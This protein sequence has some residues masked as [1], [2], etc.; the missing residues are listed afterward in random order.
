[1]TAAT[2]HARRW[3][4]VAA[5]AAGATP[6]RW[7][8]LALLLGGVLAALVF[9]PAAW[10]AQLVASATSQRVLLA[11]AQGTVWQGDAVLVLG[12]GD[13]SRAAVA[14]PGRLTWQLSWVGTGF[15][16][17]ARQDCCLNDNFRLLVEPGFGRMRL[18]LQPT[19]PSTPTTPTTP[20]TA[21]TALPSALGQW[22]TAWLAGL[23]A[24]WNTLQLGGV[25]RLHSTGWVLDSAQGRH[26]FTGHAELAVEGLSSRLSTLPLLGNYKLTVDGQ[27]QAGNSAALALSTQQGPLL[28]N[29]TGQFGGAMGSSANTL[30]FRGEARA[31]PEA[32][33]ALNNLLNVI[34][35]RQGAVSVLSIG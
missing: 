33:N 29:G 9:P 2:R 20:T 19:T 24:P 28:L 4:K 15:A 35:R 6:K 18:S 26:A 10:L 1:M 17:R 23:G 5:G 12:G 3:R 7:L 31:A 22:P 8:L 27:P 11:D 30:R 13:G 14:L 21:G 25:M 16:L 32:E 34:G